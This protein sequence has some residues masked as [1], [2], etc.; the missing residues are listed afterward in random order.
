MSFS[1]NPIGTVR[2]E[3]RTV[4]RH[5]SVSDVSGRLVI[6]PQYTLGLK[7]IKPGD[8]IVVLFVFDRSEE[9]NPSLLVQRPPHTGADTGVFSI[10]SPRRPNPVG[11]SVVKVDKVE[12][13][14]VFVHG[15]D[16]FDGTPIID[17]KPA[18]PP[19]AK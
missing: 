18:F 4:P 15:L 11:L 6:D 9:F 3:S 17:I 12:D 14:V 10:C 2:H 8:E 5:Y 7:D 19:P 13:N 1:I 16:M